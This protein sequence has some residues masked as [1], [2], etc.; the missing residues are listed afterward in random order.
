M[1][2][3]SKEPYLFWLLSEI[4]IV[5]LCYKNSDLIFDVAIDQPEGYGPNRVKNN[6]P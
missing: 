2:T 1:M 4:N 6:I 3:Q 5:L